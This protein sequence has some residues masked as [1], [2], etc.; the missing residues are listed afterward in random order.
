M[1]AIISVDIG[2]TTICGVSISTS[3]ELIASVERP[4]IAAIANLATEH[5]E[6]EPSRI[7][8]CVF[9]ILRELSAAVNEVICVGMTGQMH[10]MLCVNAACEPLTPLITWQDG[11]C[12]EPA[13]DGRSY[14]EH[15]YERVPEEAWNACGCRPASGFMG[16]TL[17]W[18]RCNNVFRWLGD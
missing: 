12:L 8:D 7:R 5:A 16:S 10:G 9:E 15:M 6:Q 18:M 4:N 3:G 11:R 2:T 14:L 13:I 1:R 17:F